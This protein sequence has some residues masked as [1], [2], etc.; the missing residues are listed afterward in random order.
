MVEIHYSDGPKIAIAK[1]EDMKNWALKCQDCGFIFCTTCVINPNA[2]VSIPV[3]PKC[4]SEG[5][6]YLFIK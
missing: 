3:C 6:P 5:G 4:G 1:P 2:D